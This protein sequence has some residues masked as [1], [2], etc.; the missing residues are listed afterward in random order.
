LPFVKIDLKGTLLV[1]SHA[2]RDTPQ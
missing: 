1:T 2:I